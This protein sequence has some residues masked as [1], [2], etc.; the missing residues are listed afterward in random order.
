KKCI[1]VCPAEAI[2]IFFTPEEEALLKELEAEGGA[3]D[4]EEEP[5]EEKKEGALGAEADISL[6]NGVWVY[7]EQFEGHAHD[8]SW[9]LLGKGRELANDLGV[10]LAAFVLG[11]NIKHLSKD[12]FG[13]GADKVYVMD[14]PSLKK[15]RT[16]SYLHG[17]VELVNKYK[18]EIVLM[19]ATGLG[20]DL[21]GAVATD[22]KTGLTADCT[23][24]CI[25]KKMRIL[26]QTRPA[27]GGNIMATI[28]TE[29]RRPQ[30]ASVRPHVMPKPE[31]KEGATGEVIE[32]PFTMAEE[33]I[34][35]QVLEIIKA[36]QE[37]AVN[38]A[39]AKVVVAGG[40]GMLNKEN[41]DKLQELADILGGVVGGT[42]CAFDEGW[43]E[44]ARQ[45]GQT[46]KTVHP[47]LYIACAIS[48][49]IQHLV[50]M[51]DSEFI[52]AINKDKTAPVFE[53][54]HL[55]IVGD[56]FEIIP[57]LVEKLKQANATAVE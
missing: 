34:P 24:L 12:A 13:Y 6:W 1:K 10:E 43:M 5:E 18:P 55:G 8:V 49:A 54:A 4:A 22:L 44:H 37:N 52:I 31:L 36:A 33:D 2:E 38:I 23:M 9:E 47:K 56:V 30:M 35:A 20:R 57:A 26:E 3:A 32:E 28:L 14:H 17:T 45:V 29:T 53:V 16:N 15:Y 41:F 46:G 11:D 21:A 40:R 42:R 39:G 51:Q 27:F 7:V 50:G 25:D 48:G 19:G